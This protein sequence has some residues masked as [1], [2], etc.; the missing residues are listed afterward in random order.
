MFVI[1]FV[2]ACF[3]EIKNNAPGKY[4]CQYIERRGFIFPT[5]DFHCCGSSV[6]LKIIQHSVTSF[7]YIVVDEGNN[8][9]FS[10]SYLYY[11]HYRGNSTQYCVIG[12]EKRQY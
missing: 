4:E 5:T 1:I 10:V 12:I 7:R 9:N 8:L 3:N 2:S 6:K 11:M